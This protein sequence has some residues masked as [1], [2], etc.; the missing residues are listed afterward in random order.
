MTNQKRVSGRALKA[1][2][3]SHLLEEDPEKGVAAVLEYPARQA[4][5]PLFGLFHSREEILRWRAVYA[6]GAVT[7]ALAEENLESARVILRRLMWNL[8]DESGGIGWGSPEA[9]GEI[10]ARHETLAKEFGSILISYIKEE[11]NFLE[12]PLLQRGSLWG[13]GRLAKDRPELARDA[14]SHLILFLS[15]EDPVLRGLA[16]R[17]LGFIGDPGAGPALEKLLGD[18]ARVEIFEDG[19]FVTKMV[20]EIAGDAM[21]L[22]I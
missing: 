5:N 7:A 9:M 15:A 10:L 14:V 3:R 16:A 19:G 11:G 17:A 8:N 20:G 22:R 6:M 4:V 18:G 1:K 13:V 21:A 2:I 12:H